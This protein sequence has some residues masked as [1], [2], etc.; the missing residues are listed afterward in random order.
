[1]AHVDPLG[2][3]AWSALMITVPVIIVTICIVLVALAALTAR[4]PGIRRHCLNLISQL[5][6]VLRVLRR[7][8]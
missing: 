1:V 6:Q 7:Q 5:T 4:R 8:L 2:D 3:L